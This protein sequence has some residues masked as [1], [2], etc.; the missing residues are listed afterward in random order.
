[1]DWRRWPLLSPRHPRSGPGAQTEIVV[2]YAIPDLFKEVH[3]EVAKQFMAANPTIKVKFLQPAK[4]YEDATQQVLRNAVTGQLPDVTYQGL[5]RQRIFAD[6]NIASARRADRRREGLGQSGLR[7][8]AADLGQVKGKQYG[9]GFSLS[10]P[11]IYF[12]ADLVK[13]AGGDPANFPKT[14]EGI[15]RSRAR[16]SPCRTTRST[17]FHFDWDITGNWMWQALVFSN[18]G[19]M[20]TPTRRR[21]RSTAWPDRKRSD[22]LRRMMTRRQHAR[23]QPGHGACRISS[24]GRLGIW[25]HSTSRLGGVTKQWRR[26]SSTLRTA[27]FPLCAG[28]DKRA[29]RPAATSR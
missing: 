18:G 16:K 11:I 19:T 15:F 20:L 26:A 10:T 21:S 25:A 1:M 4:E 28:A 2:Q 8:R 17:G 23:C 7:R 6:R 27:T 3:E 13:K 9:M 29:C 12:N 5:N 14:W 22:S 24:P